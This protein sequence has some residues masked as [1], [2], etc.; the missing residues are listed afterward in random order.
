MG[1][2]TKFVPKWIIIRIISSLFALQNTIKSF[3]TQFC[4]NGTKSKPAKDDTSIFSR[5]KLCIKLC[6][7][8][9]TKNMKINMLCFAWREN[10]KLQ[11]ENILKD[12]F[13]GYE[14]LLIGKSFDNRFFLVYFHSILFTV[15]TASI[16]IAWFYSL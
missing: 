16:L 14:K 13:S 9:L 3:L 11:N 2:T 6:N 5:T 10:N 1:V 4:A 8:S 12:I 7:E 15:F